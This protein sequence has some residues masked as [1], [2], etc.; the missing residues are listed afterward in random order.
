[1]KDSLSKNGLAVDR[2]QELVD[3]GRL[4][5]TSYHNLRPNLHFINENC[6]RLIT[7][8]SSLEET[9]SPLVCIVY[10]IMKDI[11]QYLHAGTSKSRFGVET[12]CLLSER[13]NTERERVTSNFSQNI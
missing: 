8:L 10:N 7:V 6:I 9:K 13:E 11:K 12:S 1:M 4:P 5:H 2:I 3:D